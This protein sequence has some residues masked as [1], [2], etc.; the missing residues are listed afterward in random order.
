MLYILLG[1]I[2]ITIGLYLFLK[3]DTG[4][5][6]D[7]GPR[8]FLS[9]KLLGGL[10]IIAGLISFALTSFV[11]IDARSVGHLK[12]IYAWNELPPGRIIALDGQKGPHR[13]A[14]SAPAFTSFPLCACFI[15]LRNKML[16]LF[17]MVLM[18]RSQPLMARPCP[19][20]CLSPP[21]FQTK[22]SLMY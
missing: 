20:A 5:T 1:L 10:L 21:P 18:G 12:R 2:V 16:S 7:G 13:P 15:A 8:D 14:Y 3:K 19:K 6:G 9:S 17:Q 4:G 11:L 22:S